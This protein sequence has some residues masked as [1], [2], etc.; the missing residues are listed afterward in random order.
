[1]TTATVERD[2]ASVPPYLD[3]VADVIAGLL[4][5]AHQIGSGP[6]GDRPR[7][8]IELVARIRRLDA[9]IGDDDGWEE[10]VAERLWMIR[11]ARWTR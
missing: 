6:P 4:D 8:L 7:H 10:D 1:M 5:A 2:R 11:G 3:E 9:I